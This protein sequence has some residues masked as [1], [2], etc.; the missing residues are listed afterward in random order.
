M[1]R[2][3]LTVDNSFFARWVNQLKLLQ[4]QVRNVTEAAVLDDGQLLPAG[5]TAKVLVEGIA[6]PLASVCM[7]YTAS[8]IW[9]WAR[10]WKLCSTFTRVSFGQQFQHEEEMNMSSKRVFLKPVGSWHAAWL[11]CLQL[12]PLLDGRLTGAAHNLQEQAESQ[13]TCTLCHGQTLPGVCLCW[14]IKA[15][16]QANSWRATPFEWRSASEKACANAN[17][18]SGIAACNIMLEIDT[19]YLPISGL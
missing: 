18:E 16:T 3:S 15:E 1:L 6:R 2:K 8:K 14:A 13:H 12:C 11:W 19:V 17:T 9:M 10:F 7:Y 5:A 4:K